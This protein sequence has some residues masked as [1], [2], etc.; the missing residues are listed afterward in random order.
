M[1][2][3]FPLLAFYLARLASAQSCD[4]GRGTCKYTSDCHAPAGNLCPGPTSYQCIPTG[5]ASAAPRS[6][7]IA[8]RSVKSRSLLLILGRFN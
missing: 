5:C 8:L 6:S 4:G 3:S 7:A 2:F 1:R